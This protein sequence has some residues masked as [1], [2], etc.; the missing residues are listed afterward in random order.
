MNNMRHLMRE[1]LL[2]LKLE[3]GVDNKNKI[4]KIQQAMEDDTY[5]AKEFRMTK[6]K[7][8][9]GNFLVLYGNPPKIEGG[10]KEVSV[11]LGFNFIQHI[12]IGK[13]T[14]YVYTTLDG[15]RKE[16]K[17]LSTAENTMCKDIFNPEL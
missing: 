7:M 13:L 1:H 9:A 16:Y 5:G 12:T 4:Q 3:E 14:T 11:Y 10:C 2:S 8:S 15:E 17:K 6:K